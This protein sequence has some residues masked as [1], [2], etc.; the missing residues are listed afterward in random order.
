MLLDGDA[1]ALAAAMETAANTVGVANISF[2]TQT[3]IYGRRILGPARPFD[4][5]FF[6]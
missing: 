3:N 2:F 1:S 4:P 6:R 5:R